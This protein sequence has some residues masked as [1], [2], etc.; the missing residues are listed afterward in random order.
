MGPEMF[1]PMVFPILKI[2]W[3]LLPNVHVI[4]CCYTLILRY[5]LVYALLFITS[6]E[7]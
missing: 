1:L 6:L 5:I 7:S 3:K 2:I 4:R